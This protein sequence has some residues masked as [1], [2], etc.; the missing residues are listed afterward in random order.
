M[1]IVI[2]G[3][4]KGLGLALAIGF[5][6]HGDKVVI[7]SRNQN[8][9]SSV[10]QRLQLNFP[11]DNVFGMVCD[12]TKSSD[13][14][15]LVET[16]VN[17][18]GSIDFWINNAGIGVHAPLVENSDEMLSQI[19]STNL[20]G[21]LFGCREVLKLYMKQ[22][23]GHIVNIAGRGS[24][25]DGAENMVAYTSTKRSLDVLNKSLKKEI[26]SDSICVHLVSPGM[27]MTDLLIQNSL[28]LRTKKVFNIL[29]EH[30]TIVAKKLVPK[31][32]KFNKT[33]QNV[34]LLTKPK[35]VLRFL[36][37]F[38][39]KNKFFDEEGN[40]TVSINPLDTLVSK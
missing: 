37:A 25:G 30:P 1:N 4:T 26:S 17:H 7:S 9:V 36:L 2:T 8:T 13:V 18:L 14:T 35:A 27:V 10:L 16:S 22:N 15:N 19:V 31:I 32:I 28:S 20:L 23:H 6:E 21:T 24:N 11:K 12:V 39:Y 5:L 34:D 3:S 33:G 38:K 29:A 40:L